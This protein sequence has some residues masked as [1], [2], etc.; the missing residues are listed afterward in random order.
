[1]VDDRSR[2]GP[3]CYNVDDSQLRTSPKSN[4]YFALCKDSRKD[5]TLKTTPD[6][7]GP[8]SYEVSKVIYRKSHN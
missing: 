1:M 3:G 5:F 8:V 6:S 2:I 7:V 4:V